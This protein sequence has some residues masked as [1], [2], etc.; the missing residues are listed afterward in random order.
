MSSIKGKCALMGHQASVATSALDFAAANEALTQAFEAAEV[1]KGDAAAATVAETIAKRADDLIGVPARDPVH[2]ARKVEAFG[3]LA[4]L[5]AGPLTPQ[6]IRTVAASQQ[7]D[8][9]RLLAIYLDLTAP[10]LSATMEE[11]GTGENLSPALT[12]RGTI[13]SDRAEWEAALAKYEAAAAE[14]DR[15]AKL[16]EGNGEDTSEEWEAAAAVASEALEALLLTRAP[17][18]VAMGVKA[19]LVIADHYTFYRGDD[20]SDPVFIAGLLAGTW[21]ETLAAALYQD[22]L[23]LAGVGGPVVE[24]KPDTFNAGDWLEAVEA[25]T[26]SRM[27]RSDDYSPRVHFEGG[28][29]D[30]ANAR[31]SGL[32]EGHKG[33]VETAAYNRAR[34][35]AYDAAGPAPERIPSTPEELQAIFARGLLNTTPADQREAL[36]A[37]LAAF[38]INPTE[39]VQ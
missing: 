11:R 4:G 5:F 26:G 32:R 31:L 15:L 7:E 34:R 24:A 12:A 16:E 14:R 20:A 17:D 8:A 23:A 3:W 9:K 37:A 6:R 30:A 27:V 33:D 36:T 22:G 19:R 38:G 10:P 29:A 39:A 1:V 13:K 35:E 28:D 18:G 25:E 21:D 2:I